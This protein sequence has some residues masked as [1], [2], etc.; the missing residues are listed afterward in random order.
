MQMMELRWCHHEPLKNDML[1][2]ADVQNIR[3]IAT[4]NKGDNR[5]QLSPL[6]ARRPTIICEAVIIPCACI[7][8]NRVGW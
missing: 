8:P 7:F 6:I 5:N 1:D 2:C 3:F 4:Y